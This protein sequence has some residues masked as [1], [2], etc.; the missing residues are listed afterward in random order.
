M[1]GPARV[2]LC[3]E[4]ILER[5]TS[6]FPLAMLLFRTCRSCTAAITSFAML[7]DPSG[8]FSDVLLNLISGSGLRLAVTR[9]YSQPAYIKSRRP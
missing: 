3:R 8:P 9:S 4:V 1:V 7:V 5:A 2:R 6:T